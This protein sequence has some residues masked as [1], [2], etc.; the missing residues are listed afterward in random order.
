[1]NLPEYIHYQFNG[2]AKAG[3]H[4][5]PAKDGAE[6]T[7]S[8][9]IAL[10]LVVLAAGTA[11]FAYYFGGLAWNIMGRTVLLFFAALAF[12]WKFYK[13][14]SVSWMLNG[15]LK[16]WLPVLLL[17][18]ALVTVVYIFV[19]LL[20]GNI[21]E[22]TLALMAGVLMFAIGFFTAITFYHAATIATSTSTK[23]GAWFA[24]LIFSGIMLGGLFGMA[25]G[26]GIADWFVRDVLR[27]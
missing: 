20:T 13:G 9:F 15:L 4:L 16:Y 1:M 21:G 2:F 19:E 3:K 7:V 27:W 25:Y 18:Y 17:M 22:Y 10:L 26:V 12:A 24:T 23:L 6:L 8:R 11:V 5:P 14:V